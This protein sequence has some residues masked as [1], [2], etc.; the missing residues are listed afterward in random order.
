M[1]RGH[2]YRSCRLISKVDKS[3]I[4]TNLKIYF[5]IFFSFEGHTPR[6]MEVPRLGVESE[7]LPLA[8]ARATAMP[9]PSHVCNLHHSSRQCQIL[10]PLSKPGRDRI[11]NL[12]VP[13]RIHFHCATTGNSNKFENL[14]NMDI[15]LCPQCTY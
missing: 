4:S 2:C 14:N 3:F 8:Y 9:N 5:F 1:K 7:L 13:S 6:H 15:F 10:N 12:M 11:R